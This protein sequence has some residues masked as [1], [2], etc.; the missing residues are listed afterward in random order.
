MGNPV[1]TACPVRTTKAKYQ[2]NEDIRVNFST[3]RSGCN[4]V[5]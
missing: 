1:F 2:Q 4:L 3:V 5:K